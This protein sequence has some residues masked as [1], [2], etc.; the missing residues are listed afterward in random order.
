MGTFCC[1]AAGVAVQ[2]PSTQN[3]LAAQPV[4]VAQVVPPQWAASLAR[5]ASQPLAAFESQS[6]N[7]VLQ[8]NPL[9]QTPAVQEVGTPL[10]GAAH[11][12]AQ[13]P[14]WSGSL[15]VLTSQP[16]PAFAS[17]SAKPEMQA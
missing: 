12:T 2:T 9:W 6:A 13:P 3:G 11:F 17:Q 5:L 8:A 7:P 4:E 16:V 14:Q 1:T 10:S 15:A